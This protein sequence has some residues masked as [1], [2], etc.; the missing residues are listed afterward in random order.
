MPYTATTT[1]VAYNGRTYYFT[2]I[3][4]TDL[5]VGEE[6]EIP[7]MPTH[8]EI[9]TFSAT[10]VAGRTIQPAFGRAT[11]FDPTD[12]NDID[13]MTQQDV[14]ARS[15]VNDQSAV[16]YYELTDGTLFGQSTIDGASVGITTTE[17][18]IIGGEQV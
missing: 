7:G 16:R 3:L 1:R 17:I 15:F 11:G 18:L 8:G 6:Y 12:V 10:T 14:A 5:N 2:Q 9:V 13:F 4:E